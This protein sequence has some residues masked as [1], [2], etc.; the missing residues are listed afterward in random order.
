[1]SNDDLFYI[2]ESTH[3]WTIAED[4]KIWIS[5]DWDMEIDARF[6]LQM[7]A[8]YWQ[9][10]LDMEDSEMPLTSASP[11]DSNTNEASSSEDTS[12]SR[13]ALKKRSTHEEM[14]NS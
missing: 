13:P 1:M 14:R 12:P 9:I 8:N 6:P 5:T 7:L 10:Q 3:Q 2:E 4:L 11:E